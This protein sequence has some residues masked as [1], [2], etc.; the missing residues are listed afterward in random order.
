[1][2][3]QTSLRLWPGIAIVILQVLIWVGGPIVFPDA[4][5]PVGM[6]GALA[7]A[8]AIVVWWVFFSRA[9]WAERLGAVILMILAVVTTR[10]IAHESMVGA[11]QGMLI[12]MMPPLYLAPAL[13]LWAVATRHLQNGARR[14]LLVAAILLAAAPFALMRTA[15]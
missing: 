7:S 10:Q 15:G 1:M 2:S 4:Q 11:G 5:L 9:V 12:Y 13:V 6:L 14:A 3:S 8:V